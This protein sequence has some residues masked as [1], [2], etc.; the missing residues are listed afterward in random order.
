MD[1]GLRLPG[2]EAPV[3]D[4]GLPQQLLA[5]D[6]AKLL[7]CHALQLKHIKVW[8]ISFVHQTFTCVLFIC[9]GREI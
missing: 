2:P 4:K 8:A 6:N 7:L 3:V 9:A 5:K 1:Q